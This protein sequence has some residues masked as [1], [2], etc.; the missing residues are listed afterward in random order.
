MWSLLRLVLCSAYADELNE[1]ISNSGDEKKLANP[2]EYR[3]VQLAGLKGYQYARDRR[4]EC[5]G[6]K[7]KLDPAKCEER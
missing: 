7:G 2:V 5:L 1:F 3:A 6:A 4:L